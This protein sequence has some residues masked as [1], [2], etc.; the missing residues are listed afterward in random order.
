MP[1]E[2]YSPLQQMLLESGL[3]AVKALAD[4]CHNDRVPLAT[5]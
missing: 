5:G 4:L 2:E 3:T 1:A